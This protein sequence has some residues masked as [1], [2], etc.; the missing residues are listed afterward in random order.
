[1][2]QPQVATESA[3][4]PIFKT[5]NK[6]LDFHFKKEKIKNEKGEQIGEGKKHP[7]LKISTPVLNAE[8][9]VEI[10]SAGGK[11]LELLLDAA[12]DVISGQVRNLINQVREKLPT[13]GEIKPDMIDQSKLLWSFIASIPKAERRGLG[14]SDEDFDAFFGDYRAIMPKV[15]GKDADRIEKHVAIFK[16]RYSVCRNDKKALQVLLDNLNLWATNTSAMEENQE[17]FEYL[18]KRAETL[19]AEE[20]KVLADNL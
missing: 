7:S 16:K 12:N 17:V 20:D 9:L 2:D 13:D 4:L 1:M 14:I 10:I 3:A 15:T 6:D 19:L 5:E 8:G 11:S 18:K